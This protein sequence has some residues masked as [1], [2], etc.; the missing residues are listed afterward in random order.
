MPLIN[1]I[2]CVQCVY[3]CPTIF[4]VAIVRAVTPERKILL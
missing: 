1:H 3:F 4:I 2:Y